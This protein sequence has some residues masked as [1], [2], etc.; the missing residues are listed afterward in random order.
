MKLKDQIVIWGSGTRGMGAYYAL[1]KSYEIL[2][3]LDSD[4]EKK[5]MEIVDGKKVLES[6]PAGCLVIIACGRWM[7]VSR[8]LLEKGLRLCMDFLPYHMLMMEEIRLNDLL[9]CF[10]AEDIAAYLKE[11]RDR[12]Q[13]ALIYGNCQID[14]MA[15]MMEYNEE[16]RRRYI[17]LRVPPVHLY[18]DEAHIEK[19]LYSDEI[20]KLV[21]LFIFQCVRE[22]NR[23]SAKLGT[24]HIAEG[25]GKGCRKV[26]IHNLYFDG[27]FI[28]YDSDEGKYLKNMD[29]KSFPYTDVIVDMLL[30]D[31]KGTEEIIQLISKDDF[32]PKEKIETRCRKSIENLCA[33]EK[34]VDVPIV[35]YIREHYKREQLFYTHNHPK[36]IVIYEYV[37]RILRV[38][39][40]DCVDEFTE[41]EL[42]LEFGTLRINNFPVYP[43]VVKALGLEKYETKARISHISPGLVTMRQYIREYISRCCGVE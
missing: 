10:R 40:I 8:L 34:L 38:L 22:D 31:K 21:D 42:N 12:K 20:M 2:G 6:K 5:H 39:E 14:I 11:V 16:F 35:D 17:L 28:Q 26:C 15:N 13:V 1:R 3:F 4:P 19:V 37:K 18:K 9:Y 25:M 33:R 27:Y 7:E 43:C 30:E 23:Y 36:N 41:E 24:A 32:V 29:E